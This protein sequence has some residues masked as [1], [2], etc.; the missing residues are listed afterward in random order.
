MAGIITGQKIEQ[1][2]A[3]RARQLRRQMT[4]A[5]QI[6]WQAL[7]ANRLQGWHFRRQQVIFY[8][9]AARLIVE[10][11]GDIHEQQLVYD[12]DRD[13][14]LTARGLRIL[15]FRNSEILQNLEQVLAHI[16]EACRESLSPP[17]LGEGPG[18]RS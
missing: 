11:D 15:R 16:A 2:K 8:C 13:R 7:R 18:E 17:S 6:L 10:I 4:P 1:S 12:E 14:V 5:E 9:H 3:L